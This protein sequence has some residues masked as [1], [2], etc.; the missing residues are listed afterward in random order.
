MP[1]GLNNN[2]DIIKLFDTENNLQ[3]EFK[4]SLSVAN[5]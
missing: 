2:G 5:Q 4:Y 3:D 1:M